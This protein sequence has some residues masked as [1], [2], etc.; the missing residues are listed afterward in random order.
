MIVYDP[1]YGKFSLPDDL[2]PLISSPEVRRLSQIRL[3]NTLTPSLAVLGEL[4]RYSH[5]LG[6]LHLCDKNKKLVYSV[7]AQ[8]ALSASVLLHDIGT[9]PFGHLM[10]YH[11]RERAGW[12]HEE[13]I[14]AVLWGYHVP[15][16]RAHQIFA[17]RTIEFRSALEKANISLELVEA[18]ISKQHPMSALLFGSIDLD[19]LDNVGRMAWAM[20]I[21]TEPLLGSMLASVLTI[22]NNPKLLACSRQYEDEVA[23]W[24]ALRRIVYEILVFDPPTVAAQAVLSNAISI[25]LENEILTKDDWSLSDEELLETLRTNPCTKDMIIQ[26]YLAHLPSLVFCI[27]LTGHTAVARDKNRAA[28][29][30]MIEEVLH[31][32]FPKSRSLGYVF[33]DRG[34]FEK[35][36]K[37]LDEATQSPWEIGHT[38]NSLIL[39]GFISG[40]PPLS[41]T[42]CSVAAR[43]L[44]DGLN[45]SRDQVEQVRIGP[46]IEQNHAQGSFDFSPSSC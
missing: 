34:T 23:R 46:F 33:V 29:K 9:S 38:S 3:L 44:L 2:L 4:R 43:S 19:N 18:I 21:N 8:R 22:T 40:R 41:K 42:R 30:R 16:N 39:Y 35:S 15:E 5:T 1:L 17:G 36:L 14:R 28:L 27:Q 20:G 6:V 11:L 45:I 32:V 26:E 24:L 7:D 25:G 31:S 13:I 37:F 10:E 12:N